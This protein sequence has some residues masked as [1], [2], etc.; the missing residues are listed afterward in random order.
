MKSVEQRANTRYPLRL[1]VT[2]ETQRQRGVG[3]SVD[4][5]S[6]GARLKLDRVLPVGAH[7][8]VDINW[9]IKLTPSVPL[10]LRL[11]GRVIRTDHQHTAVC[12]RRHLFITAGRRAL[13]TDG[14]QVRTRTASAQPFFGDGS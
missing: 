10:R 12:F 7:V 13:P 8:R 2:Y 9:P 3:M 14:S 1:F 6:K 5:S 11:D 4:L